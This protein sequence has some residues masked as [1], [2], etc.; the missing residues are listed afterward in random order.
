[1]EPVLFAR[2]I[3]H[4]FVQKLVV[5]VQT[6]LDKRGDGLGA[7]LDGRLW[8]HVKHSLCAQNRLEP[9]DVVGDLAQRRDRAI[10]E[11]DGVLQRRDGRLQVVGDGHEEQCG[12]ARTRVA[13]FGLNKF[14]FN[15]GFCGTRARHSRA[16]LGQAAVEA[17]D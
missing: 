12:A 10:E 9:I 16:S 8:D 7:F 5:L 1:M 11:I 3:G 15:P 17:R 2:Q 13:G 4:D 6:G 14:L